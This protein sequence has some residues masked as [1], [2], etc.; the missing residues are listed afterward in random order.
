[1]YVNWWDNPTNP[2][3]WH[4]HQVRSAAAVFEAAC[5]DKPLQLLYL[6]GDALIHTYDIKQAHTVGWQDAEHGAAWFSFK[7][8]SAKTQ[9]MPS[10]CMWQ[11]MRK[12]TLAGTQQFQRL[13]CVSVTINAVM[14]GL[15]FAVCSWPG[16]VWRSGAL[17]STLPLVARRR[18]QH[19]QQQRR[20]SQQQP[21]KQQ[22][23]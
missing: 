17:S 22:H 18:R 12:I 16:L 1:M 8:S 2:D 13:C 3:S 6:L 10:G 11:F 21:T 9:F 4:K 20:L 14:S 7:S 5:Q 15:H 19:Q 23:Q